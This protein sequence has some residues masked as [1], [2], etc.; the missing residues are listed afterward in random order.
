MYYNGSKFTMRHYL[1]NANC[2]H[3]IFDSHSSA[4]VHLFVRL[5]F[6]SS[7]LP[8]PV[9]LS[10]S[11]RLLLAGSAFL[12]FLFVVFSRWIDFTCCIYANTGSDIVALFHVHCECQ[13]FNKEW[14]AHET[15]TKLTSNTSWLNRTKSCHL[16]AFFRPCLPLWL[17]LVAFQWLDI[18]FPI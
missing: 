10:L 17:W 15:Q 9:A 2:V 13:R 1:Q 4:L 18:E 7:H 5:A 14:C 8:L 6:V 3:I 11:R 16:G 12:F